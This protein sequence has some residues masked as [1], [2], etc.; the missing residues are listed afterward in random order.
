MLKYSLLLLIFFNT[1]LNIYKITITN[2]K[3]SLTNTIKTL[4]NHEPSHF[5]K[6]V[7]YKLRKYYQPPQDV[8]TI[9]IF[10][11]QIYNIITKL[12]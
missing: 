4:K 12:T 2:A 6:T 9:K 11:I 8:A 3:K 5:S 7:T 10:I 1:S